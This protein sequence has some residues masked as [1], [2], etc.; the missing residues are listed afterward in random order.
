MTDSRQAAGPGDRDARQW[1]AAASVDAG[2]FALCP[3]HAALLVAADAL[4][5]DGLRA[6]ADDLREA[7]AAQSP[8]ATFATRLITSAG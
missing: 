8:D 5:I 1:L 3:G 7:L 6:A 4:G 2:V